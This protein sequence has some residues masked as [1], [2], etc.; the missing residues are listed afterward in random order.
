MKKNQ[1]AA[2]LNRDNVCESNNAFST[3]PPL[4][5]EVN[6][7]S[8]YIPERLETFLKAPLFT[9]TKENELN[10]RVLK[11]IAQDLICFNKWETE[12]SS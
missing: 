1:G 5:E 2:K 9:D 10:I 12:N 8:I 6:S 11:S 7:K 4:Y 3:W